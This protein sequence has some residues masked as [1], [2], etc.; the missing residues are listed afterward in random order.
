MGSL[1]GRPLLGGLCQRG[2]AAE[3]DIPAGKA[4]LAVE[5]WHS[6]LSTH[7][8]LSWSLK[9]TSGLTSTSL[10]FPKAT[11]K[12]GTLGLIS[13][14]P[15]KLLTEING[16]FMGAPLSVSTLFSLSCGIYFKVGSWANQSR[17]FLNTASSGV[18]QLQQ[19]ILPKSSREISTSRNL[20][21][22]G[23]HCIHFCLLLDTDTSTFHKEFP[24]GECHPGF[25]GM[26]QGWGITAS[27]GGEPDLMERQWNQSSPALGLLSPSCCWHLPHTMAFLCKPL[28]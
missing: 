22:P 17:S 2:V 1:W 12:P 16:V 21:L 28:L 11:D 25:P 7:S 14:S 9:D 10:C 20:W 4:S 19:P 5:S 18:L 8:Q 3:L 27:L 24:T 26:G 13:Q 23:D 15:S 6:V